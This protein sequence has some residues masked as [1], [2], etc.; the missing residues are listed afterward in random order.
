MTLHMLA[1]L[2]RSG[3]TLLL[4]VLAQHPDV[5]VSGTSALANV[6]DAAQGVLSNDPTVISE[7]SAN[8]GMYARYQAA[9]RG[10]AEGWYSTADSPDVIDKG[11]AWAPLWTLARDLWPD[12]RMLVTVRDPRDVVASIER[13]HQATGL[14]RSPVAPAL[15]DA[16]EQLMMADGLVGAQIRFVEDL[17]RRRAEGVMFVRHESFV[18]SPEPVLTKI[19]EHLG[20]EPFD[21]DPENVESAGGDTDAVWRGKY[22]HQGT[23]PIKPHGGSWTDV[24]DPELGAL[25]AGVFP[26]YM[27]TFSYA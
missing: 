19:V 12:A 1:G 10:L 3:S 7:L 20:L 17:I 6:L 15:R 26:L 16:A 24:L 25:I 8:P 22:P 9:L 11:R 23:G 2:P 18:A 14:F 27:T 13:Q 21:F 5:A 4:N